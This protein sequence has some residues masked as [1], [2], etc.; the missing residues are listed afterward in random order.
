MRKLLQATLLVVT[1]AGLGVTSV[2]AAAE[3]RIGDTISSV[4]QSFTTSEGRWVLEKDG[5][6]KAGYAVSLNGKMV[7]YAVSLTIGRNGMPIAKHADGS[8]YIWT[9]STFRRETR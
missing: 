1:L 5:S 9:G 3:P 4:G 2:A 6:T 7:G 8:E